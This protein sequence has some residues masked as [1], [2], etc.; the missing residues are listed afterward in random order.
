MNSFMK[1]QELRRG[2]RVLFTRTLQKSSFSY[3]IFALENDK[4]IVVVR[5][6]R[7]RNG[8][9]KPFEVLDVIEAPCSGQLCISMIKKNTFILFKEKTNEHYKNDTSAIEVTKSKTANK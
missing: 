8:K 7:V 3:I 5:R 6:R 9:L 1:V 2:R 4:S